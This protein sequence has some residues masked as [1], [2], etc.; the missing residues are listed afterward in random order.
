M[1]N[2]NYAELWL[3]DKFIFIRN[4]GIENKNNKI[5]IYDDKN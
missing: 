4:D 5:Y 2:L 3:I 1:K